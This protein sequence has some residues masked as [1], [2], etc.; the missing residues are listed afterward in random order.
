MFS[1]LM[2]ECVPGSLIY[3]GSYFMDIC[4]T[5]SVKSSQVLFL[6]SIEIAEIWYFNSPLHNHVYIHGYEGSHM[7][8]YESMGGKA[9]YLWS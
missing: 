6:S 7:G 1:G 5:L 3:R 4:L 9:F 2:S 8:W